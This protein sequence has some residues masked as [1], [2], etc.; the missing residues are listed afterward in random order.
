MAKGVRLMEDDPL[1]GATPPPE[2]KL[3][4]TAEGAREVHPVR[5]FK[6]DPNSEEAMYDFRATP[7]DADV[8]VEDPKGSSAQEPVSS[9]SSEVKLPS[10]ETAPVA[11]DS[12]PVKVDGTGLAPSSAK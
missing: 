3:P 11:K 8:E 10:E 2:T 5:F 7:V 4:A 1:A 6:E 12:M 9:S